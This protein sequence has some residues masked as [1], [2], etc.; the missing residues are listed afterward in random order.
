[1]TNLSK[2]NNSEILTKIIDKFGKNIPTEISSALK[3]I[4]EQNLEDINFSNDMDEK[5]STET[6]VYDY[7][8]KVSPTLED[9]SKQIAE[10]LK[11]KIQ[12]EY[13]SEKSNRK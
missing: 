3:E 4:L 5:D 7:M 9:L 2:V 10:I 12:S 6:I 13:D 11:S 8:R 1:M